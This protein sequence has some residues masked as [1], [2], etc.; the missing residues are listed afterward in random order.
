MT[1][2]SLTLAVLSLAF[3]ALAACGGP[4][5]A[6]SDAAE[7]QNESTSPRSAQAGEAESA[8]A[9]SGEAAAREQAPP[10]PPPTKADDFDWPETMT[11][12]RIATSEGD[13]LVELYAEEAPKTVDNFLQY[14]KDG[15]FDRTIFHRV[16]NGF[17]IQGGGYNAYFKERPTRDPIP[18]EGDNGLP[19]YRGTLAMARTMDPDSAAAQ[20]YINLRDNDRLNHLEND[21]GVRPGYA[22]FGRVIEGM[23]VVD[24]VGADRPRRALSVGSSHRNHADRAGRPGGSRR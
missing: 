5:E 13:I 15:H 8:E 21:L 7:R 23:D 14:A 22:V 24:R 19:N 6:P 1:P 18:Y 12:A 4:D 2:K 3:L 10:P 17:V 20:W 9:D 16:V 11:G